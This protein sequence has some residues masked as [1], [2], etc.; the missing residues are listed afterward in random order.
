M[1][2]LLQTENLNFT[3]LRTPKT[4]KGCSTLSLKTAESPIGKLLYVSFYRVWYHFYVQGLAPGETAEFVL[5]NL[6]NQ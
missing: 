5:K 3:S 1:A 4:H 6:S 2:R